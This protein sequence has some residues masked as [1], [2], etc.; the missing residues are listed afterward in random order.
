M[1]SKIWTNAYSAQGI[2][3]RNKNQ[4]FVWNEKITY[5]SKEINLKKGT[6]VFIEV[7]SWKSLVF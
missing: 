4:S 2:G 6:L 3:L 7:F 5:R 1:V